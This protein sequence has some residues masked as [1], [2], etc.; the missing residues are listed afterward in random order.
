M[1]AV[2]RPPTAVGLA[3][4]ATSLLLTLGCV[5]STRK[6][7][8]SAS[9]PAAAGIVDGGLEAMAS[10]DVRKDL[11]V[12]LGDD[13]LHAGMRQTTHALVGGMLD[14][15]D[16]VQRDPSGDGPDAGVA[17][18][19][20]ALAY[21]VTKGTDR[22]LAEIAERKRGQGWVGYIGWVTSTIGSSVINGVLVLLGIG[23]ATA[24]ALLY[25]RTQRATEQA[26]SI[27]EQA[28]LELLTQLAL[29][30]DGDPEI[31]R[32]VRALAASPDGDDDGSPSGA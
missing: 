32:R 1:R 16:E 8:A 4:V 2:L 20:E 21:G 22:A 25:Q 23:L 26:R 12:V 14:A 15:I 27:R 6:V 11:A 5:A 9:A 19:A 31:A 10:E 13:D 7:A 18:I 29:R 30:H 24:T 3:V 17:A 28:M